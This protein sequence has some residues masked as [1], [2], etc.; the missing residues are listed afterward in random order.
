MD[1]IRGLITKWLSSNRKAIE[2]KI[3]VLYEVFS[4]KGVV[5]KYFI[6]DLLRHWIISLLFAY[7]GVSSKLVKGRVVD[8]KRAFSTTKSAE[9]LKNSTPF[10][11]H[12]MIFWNT[13]WVNIQWN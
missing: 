3:K 4:P 5:E 13:F 11:A 10:A 8:L 12:A 9:K 1:E 6:P 2:S 7:L